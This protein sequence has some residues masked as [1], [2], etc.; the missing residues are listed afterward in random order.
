MENTTETIRT[1]TGVLA[2]IAVLVTFGV[3][4]TL[5]TVYPWPGDPFSVIGDG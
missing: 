3:G 1:L 5:S 4:A 2:P